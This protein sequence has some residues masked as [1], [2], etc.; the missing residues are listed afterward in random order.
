[1]STQ[2]IE[3]PA[4]NQWD[5]ATIRWQ[6]YATLT[7]LD[8]IGR[9]LWVVRRYLAFRAWCDKLAQPS[10]SEIRWVESYWREFYRAEFEFAAA[11]PNWK[12]T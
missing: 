12:A 8:S 7:D 11:F 3:S 2:R 10:A 4:C 9:S 1:M 5:D 6:V